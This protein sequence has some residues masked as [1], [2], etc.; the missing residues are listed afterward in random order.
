MNPMELALA[1]CLAESRYPESSNM[2]DQWLDCVFAVA[3]V[4]LQ[5][6][7]YFNKDEFVEVC[8]GTRLVR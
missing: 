4:C 8:Q 3:N 1:K 2:D 6:R 5:H 7:P